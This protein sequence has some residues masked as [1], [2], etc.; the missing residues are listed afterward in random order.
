MSALHRGSVLLEPVSGSQ[1]KN[2]MKNDENDLKVGQSL[3]SKRTGRR[4]TIT[5]LEDDRVYYTV[6]GFETIAPV[7]L[8]REKF[9]HLVGA[10]VDNDK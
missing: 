9:L 7:F 8:A 3:H 4:L 5:A 2:L 6:D 1:R 10:G